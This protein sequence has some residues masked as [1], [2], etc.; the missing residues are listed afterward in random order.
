MSDSRTTYR[1]VKTFVKD[2]YPSELKGNLHRNMNTLTAMITGIITGKE[3]RLPEIATNVPEDIKLP[4]NEK[5][6]KRLIINEGVTKQT[7]FLPFIQSVLKNLGLEEMVLAIDGRLVGR[8]CI[9]L[10]IC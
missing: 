9:C 4:S 8:C 2:L 5:R 3:T 6:F 1:K 10:M 7:Y